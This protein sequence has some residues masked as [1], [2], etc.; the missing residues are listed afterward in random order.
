MDP[1][2]IRILAAVVFV[3]IVVI[4][5]VRRKKMAANASSLISPITVRCIK[6]P[7]ATGLGLYTHSASELSHPPT[8]WFGLRAQ[9]IAQ[10]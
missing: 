6:P 10:G 3:I 2:T 7:S 5:V 1:A 8:F 9:G 4:I